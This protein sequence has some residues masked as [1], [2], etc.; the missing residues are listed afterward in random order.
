ML[1]W[2]FS[3]GLLSNGINVWNRAGVGVAGK[4]G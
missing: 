2:L 3:I 1:A 4:T